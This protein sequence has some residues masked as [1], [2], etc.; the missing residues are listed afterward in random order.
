MKPTLFYKYTTS[1]TAERILRNGRLRWSS[2]T[3]FNDLAEFQR[4]PRFEP[5]LNESY[6][7][8][9]QILIDAAS[10]RESIDLTRLTPAMHGVLNIIT[11][12]LRRGVSEVELLKLLINFEQPNAD[13]NLEHILLE[14]FEA[15]KPKAARLLCLT[16]TY[17]NEVMWGTYADNHYGCVLGFKAALDDSPFHEAKP[18]IYSDKPAIVGSGLDLLLYGNSQ[19]FRQKTTEAVFYTKKLVWSYEQE[20]RLITW[21]YQEANSTHGDYIFYPEELDSV[22]FGARATPDFIKSIRAMSQNKYP[23]TEIFKII[24]HQGEM[25]RVHIS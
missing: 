5:T 1:S 11:E 3:V 22:T 4:M 6:K 14:H 24:H 8:L 12:K 18:I 2:P 9:H 21:R 25:S 10:G 7:L 19:E 16:S 15:L 13:V 20:W 17:H 23:E